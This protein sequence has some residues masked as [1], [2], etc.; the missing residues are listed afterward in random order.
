MV[1]VGKSGTESLERWR[2]TLQI[3]VCPRRPLGSQHGRKSIPSPLC[4]SLRS[5]PWRS[6][7][8]CCLAFL[9]LNLLQTEARLVLCCGGGPT[10]HALLKTN[11]KPWEKVWKRQMPN[12][13]G[14]HH[15]VGNSFLC[16]GD[17]SFFNGNEGKWKKLRSR[18]WNV[19]VPENWDY[20]RAALGHG[21][22]P[23]PG[24]H[25]GHAGQAVVCMFAEE[26]NCF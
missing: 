16:L 25:D 18:S 13:P 6:T 1:N 23:S 14:R 9:D 3:P 19:Q 20:L 21:E 17:F 24:A 22:L 15:W 26:L 7:G 4:R 12:Q 2:L 10:K 8:F 11:K 5:S